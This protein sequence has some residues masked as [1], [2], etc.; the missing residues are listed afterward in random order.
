MKYPKIFHLHQLDYLISNDEQ[1]MQ[2]VLK[3]YLPDLLPP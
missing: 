2:E 3:L 1:Y